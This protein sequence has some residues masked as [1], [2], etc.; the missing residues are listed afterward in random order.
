MIL[1]FRAVV[2]VDGPT[3]WVSATMLPCPVGTELVGTGPA[4]RCVECEFGL[5]SLSTATPCLPCPDEATCFGGALVVPLPGFWRWIDA[6][7]QPVFER[8]RWV[9][10]ANAAWDA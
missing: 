3:V 10:C 2:P 6:N 8:C 4:S 5:Y 9:W 7:D 1:G